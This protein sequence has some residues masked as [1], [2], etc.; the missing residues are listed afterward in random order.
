MRTLTSVLYA[1]PS[2]HVRQQQATQYAVFA[3]QYDDQKFSSSSSSSAM[4]GCGRPRE[5]RDLSCCCLT[6]GSDPRVLSLM[7]ISSLSSSSI[8][9]DEPLS[10][11]VYQTH[12]HRLFTTPAGLYWCTKNTGTQLANDGQATHTV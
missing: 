2:W 6:R 3:G 11:S 4:S 7:S 1:T 12:K 10:S 9:I 5:G 8:S